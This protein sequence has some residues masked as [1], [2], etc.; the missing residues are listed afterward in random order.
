V[1]KR[2][3]KMEMTF[4]DLFETIKTAKENKEKGQYNSILPPFPRLAEKY[5]GW[6]KGRLNLITASSGIGKTKFTK[7]FAIESVVRFMKD[8]PYLS[9]KIFYFALEES[10]E[11]FWLSMITVLLREKYKLNISTSELRSFGT[12]T[13]SQETLDKVEECKAIVDD[14]QKNITVI[15]DISNTYGIYKEVRTY[16]QKP[17]VGI[18][19]KS[20]MTT[21]EEYTSGYKYNDENHWVFVIT[22]HLSLLSANKGQTLHDTMGHFSKEY[23]LKGLCK[24]YK[25]VVINI[26]QQSASKEALEF[27]FKG[28]TIE[29]KLEPS[30]DG[31]A[32]N[33]EIQ[34]DCDMVWGI[35]APSRY[36]IKEHRKYDITI[37]KDSYRSLLC[38]KDRHFGIAGSYIGLYFDGASNEFRELPKADDK[39][40]MSKVYDF[41]KSK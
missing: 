32:N 18:E 1:K 23:C 37:M 4:D 31:L 28:D 34:R 36:S 12:Y 20:K 33:K 24:R 22:D 9:F 13:V 30:L 7:F 10:K 27:N 25:A 35:F 39:E 41:I 6:V 19:I 40:K 14:W 29:Q 11:E 2:K 16:F 15:D 26:Q 21:G 3:V 17:E 5:P 8:N 38:L